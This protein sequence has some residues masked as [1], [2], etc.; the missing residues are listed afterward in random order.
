VFLLVGCSYQCIQGVFTVGRHFLKDLKSMHTRFYGYL[1]GCGSATA[2]GHVCKYALL[3]P[4]VAGIVGKVQGYPFGTFKREPGVGL[5]FPIEPILSRPLSTLIPED[6][7]NR[8]A[9]PNT[10]Y[11]SGQAELLGRALKRTSVTLPSHDRHHKTVESL[12]HGLG[13]KSKRVPSEVPSESYRVIFSGLP[14]F[15][16]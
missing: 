14:D 10:K 8:N 11:E 15:E 9:W 12:I 4:A 3:N 6:P 5:P 1:L 16:K 7:A 2:N 13:R